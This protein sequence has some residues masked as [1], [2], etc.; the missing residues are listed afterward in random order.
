M[1]TLNDIQGWINHEEIEKNE[2]SRMIARESFDIEGYS[3]IDL[4]RYR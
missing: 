2:Y 3:R 1:Q 4:L